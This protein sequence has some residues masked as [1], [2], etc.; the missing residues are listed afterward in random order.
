MKALLQRVTNANVKVHGETI[1]HIGKGIL[2]LVGIEKHDT[3]DSIAKLLEKILNYRIFNDTDNKMN[4]CV[5]DIQGEVL[6]VS[7][8]TLASDTQKG[9]RPSF[10][11]ANTPDKSRELFDYLEN[12]A[13]NLYRDI[14]FGKFAANMKVTLC[15]DGPVTFMLEN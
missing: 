8:F 13:K 11:K 14:K 1:S 7:Q 9:L 6:I 10:N 5:R 15:N 2:V 12:H 4:L 3:R